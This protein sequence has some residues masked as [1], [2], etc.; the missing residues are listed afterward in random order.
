MLLGD[1]RACPHL[2]RLLLPWEAFNAVDVAEGFRGSVARYLGLLA[3][4]AGSLDD[5]QRHFEEALVRNEAMGAR[6]WLARAQGDYARLL[7]AR[8]LAGDAERAAELRERARATALELGVE[9]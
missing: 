4:A 5:A 2:Y 9:L 1:A 8:G 7:V 6:P 3:A